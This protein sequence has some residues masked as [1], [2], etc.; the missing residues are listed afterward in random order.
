MKIGTC[1][2]CAAPVKF[3]S[4]S[5]V[6]AVCEYCTSTLVR[7]GEVLENIG[8][9]AALQDDPTLIQIGTE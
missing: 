7:N 2:S 6:V 3:R 4:A 9:M 5:S 8:R 1:P